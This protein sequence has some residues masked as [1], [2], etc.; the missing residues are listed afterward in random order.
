[1]ESV[2]VCIGGSS[3]V[4]TVFGGCPL[5]GCSKSTFTDMLASQI[6]CP[7]WILMLGLDAAGSTMFGFHAWASKDNSTWEILGG[8]KLSACVGTHTPTD[9]FVD[10]FACWYHEMTSLY[11][12][13]CVSSS[14]LLPV[15]GSEQIRGRWSNRACTDTEA[16]CTFANAC[17]Q[18]SEHI[19]VVLGPVS[20]FAKW[21]IILEVKSNERTKNISTLFAVQTHAQITDP[22]FWV[23]QMLM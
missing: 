21:W 18:S 11:D 3:P 16:A 6:L 14:L 8:G 20:S 9:V 17:S 22:R 1:M 10:I 15:G 23:P 5:W 7:I 19:C 13:T 4:Q 2:S 12:A